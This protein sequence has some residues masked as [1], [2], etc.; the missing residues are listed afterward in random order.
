V[1]SCWIWFSWL[2]R[3]GGPAMPRRIGR[4]A[5]VRTLCRTGIWI[6]PPRFGRLSKL[7]NQKRS[8]RNS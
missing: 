4:S 7:A 1:T 2:R 3:S 6:T 5:S 8:F